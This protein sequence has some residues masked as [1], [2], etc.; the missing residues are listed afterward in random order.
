MHHLMVLRE[1]RGSAHLLAIVAQRLD[2]RTAHFIRRPEMFSTFG[3]SDDDTPTV[4]DLEIAALKGADELTDSIIAPAYAV[5]DDEGA[6]GLLGGLGA[7]APAIA[8]A[9]IPG[10]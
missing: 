1:F 4:G 6:A 5:L 9:G 3:W 7:I 2:P 10:T 8:G